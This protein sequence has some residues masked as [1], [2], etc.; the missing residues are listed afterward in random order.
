M[1]KTFIV[2]FGGIICALSV[3]LMFLSDLLPVGVYAFPIFAGVL[4]SAV[5][6]ESGYVWAFS[7]YGCVA[8]L[9]LFLVQ[10]KEAVLY[11]TA[12]FGF[13]PVLK[14]IIEKIKLKPLQFIIKYLIFNVCIIGAFYIGIYVLSIPK[15]SFNILG[16]YLPYV[17][18]IIGNAAFIVYDYMV[19]VLI[20]K[21]VLKWRKYITKKPN[22]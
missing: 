14:G 13:Y 4:L 7:V 19:S 11:Y 21:Y 5:V 18:L 12:F 9:S 17:F 1:K 20:T 22:L 6:I 16:V 2:A 8:L 10:N 15:E 3:V